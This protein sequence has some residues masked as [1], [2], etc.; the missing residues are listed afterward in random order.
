VTVNRRDSVHE[1]IDS[2]IYQFTAWVEE[3][4][5]V[6]PLTYRLDL[7]LPVLDSFR[8]LPGQFLMIR[9]TPG[10]DPLLRRP[11]SIHSMGHR[12]DEGQ[13]RLSI[14]FRAVGQGTQ[15]MAGWTQGQPVDVIGPL[16]RGY[17]TP[18]QLGTVVMIAG[19][20]GI[21]SLFGLAE[22]ILLREKRG[23]VRVYIGARSKED[24]LMKSELEDMGARVEVTTEDGSMGTMGVVTHWLE[25]KGPHL[26]KK[27]NTVVYAC[28]PL[29]MLARVASLTQR[30]SLPCQVSLETRMACGVGSCL[31]CVVRTRDKGYQ[32]VCKNGPVFDARQIDW[33]RI[34]RL[35]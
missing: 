17:T 18:E 14:L 1:S 30:V 32:L 5:P 28:G 13:R 23:D 11:F 9:T 15:L 24:V 34:G 6:S 10:F 8:I 19:G 25:T 16:G 31:G 33:E 22:S 29:E 4:R 35:L 21:A 20:L 12:S 3:N 2:K 7:F 26:A 27:G